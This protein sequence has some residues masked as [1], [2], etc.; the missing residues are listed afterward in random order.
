MGWD[1]L[2]LRHFSREYRLVVL[3]AVCQARLEIHEFPAEHDTHVNHD[4]KA[5]TL[6]KAHEPTRRPSIRD[7]MR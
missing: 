7:F 2:L 6:P 1:N 5:D 4:H 3:G